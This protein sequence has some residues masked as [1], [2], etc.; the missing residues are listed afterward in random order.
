VRAAHS[1]G[2]GLGDLRRQTNGTSDQ[3]PLLRRQ[4]S[5]DRDAWPCLVLSG[6]RQARQ[7]PPA[8]TYE[9]LV[10]FLEA[11]CEQDDPEDDGPGPAAFVEA[12]FAAA[13]NL[14]EG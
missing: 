9:A 10:A 14:P 2:R 3:P 6:D 5:D 1:C 4:G 13:V 11:D 12:G 8:Y 7:G